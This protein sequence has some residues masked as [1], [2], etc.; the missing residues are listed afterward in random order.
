MFQKIQAMIEENKPIADVIVK[1]ERIKAVL[2]AQTVADV[3]Q[4]KADT[5]KAAVK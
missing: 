5:A 3:A 1:L 2:V 4:Q